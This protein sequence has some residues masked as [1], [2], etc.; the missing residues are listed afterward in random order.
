MPLEKPF[1]L[2]ISEPRPDCGTVANTRGDR[3]GDPG[4][5]RAEQCVETVTHLVERAL[6][7][8]RDGQQFVVAQR[9]QVADGFAA[10]AGQTGLWPGRQLE[11]SDREVV[12]GD[13]DSGGVASGANF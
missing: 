6:T 9:S 10:N 12:D 13:G 11:Y 7:K 3:S 8:L 5:D 1:V 4:V 2:S